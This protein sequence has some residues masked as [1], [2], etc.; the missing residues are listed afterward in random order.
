MVS[1]GIL[2]ADQTDATEEESENGKG[3]NSYDNE[4]TSINTDDEGYI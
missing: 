3:E 4:L 1:D 2:S